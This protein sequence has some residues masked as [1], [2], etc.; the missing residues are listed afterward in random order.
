L[1][2]F[3]EHNKILAE[4]FIYKL[5]NNWQVVGGKNYG[6]R[7]G[8]VVFRPKIKPLN[9]SDIKIDKT[10]TSFTELHPEEVTFYPWSNFR[11]RYV[12]MPNGDCDKLKKID[13]CC[14]GN[15]IKN[16]SE[17]EGSKDEAVESNDNN[18]KYDKIDNGLFIQ[19][20]GQ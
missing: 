2:K 19:H 18:C 16:P 4:I 13:I 10:S 9:I 1:K 8:I 11:L 12:F 17:T 7:N 6:G 14:S 20:T 5:N 3:E 15:T